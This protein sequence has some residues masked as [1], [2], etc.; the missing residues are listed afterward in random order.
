MGQKLKVKG[1]RAPE[2]PDRQL[3]HLGFGQRSNRLLAGGSFW[4]WREPCHSGGFVG[5]QADGVRVSACFRRPAENV[6]NVAVVD[7]Y[8]QPLR[9]IALN[10]TRQKLFL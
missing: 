6:P 1:L 5:A 10:H 7:C 2:L 8:L 9:T 4:V 3:R